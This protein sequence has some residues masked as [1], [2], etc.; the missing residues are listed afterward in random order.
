M[1][2]SLATAFA[3]REELNSRPGVD[4]ANGNFWRIVARNHDAMEKHKPEGDYR[5]VVFVHF[6]GEPEPLHVGAVQSDR[7]TGLLM[8]QSSPVGGDDP[9]HFY[10]SDR[11]VFCEPSQV[12]RVEIAYVKPKPR[13]PLGFSVTETDGDAA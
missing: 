10:P 8:F 13:H 11:Y 12:A 7:R 5:A 6:V 2:R 1:P 4:S 3:A 9:E